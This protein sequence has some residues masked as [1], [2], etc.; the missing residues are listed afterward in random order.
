MSLPH[1]TSQLLTLD[2]ADY[3]SEFERFVIENLDFDLAGGGDVSTDLLNIDKEVEAEVIIRSEG[4]IAGLTEALFLFERNDISVKSNFQD[5]DLIEKGDVLFVLR[6][7]VSKI[8]SLERTLLN[9]LSRMSGI[10]TQTRRL[11]GLIGDNKCRLAATRKT[12]WGLLDKK[13]VVVGGGLPHRLRLSQA[14]MFK[15]THLKLLNR[16]FK[17]FFS[18]LLALKVEDVKKM[19]FIE[20]EL[21]NKSDVL[22]FVEAVPQSFPYKLVAM[23]DNFSVKSACEAIKILRSEI[24]IPFFIEISGGISEENITEYAQC[25]ADVISMGKLTMNPPYFDVGLEIK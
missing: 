6:A 21:E 11:V 1:D 9:F 7:K 2:N 12:L 16:D 19:A 13:A 3:L 24:K 23:L 17:G 10:A 22:A 25:G 14:V 4:V 18:L 8:L 15:D 20:F 5:G